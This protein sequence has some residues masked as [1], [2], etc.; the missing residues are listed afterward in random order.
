[1]GAVEA[2]VDNVG[3]AAADTTAVEESKDPGNNETE[4]VVSGP[5]GEVRSTMPPGEDAKGVVAELGAGYKEN[6]E[7][8]R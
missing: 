8:Q 3:V 7:R 2:T 6:T 4:L 5:R 1:M